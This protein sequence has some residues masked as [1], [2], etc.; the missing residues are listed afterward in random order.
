MKLDEKTKKTLIGIVAVIA[1]IVA[2]FGAGLLY[3]AHTKKWRKR[4]IRGILRANS[5]GQPV[6]K[7]PELAKEC[8]L[9][10]SDGIIELEGGIN[11]EDAYGQLKCVLKYGVP[12]QV[13]K[14]LTPTVQEG[15]GE[16]EAT[17]G[18]QSYSWEFVQKR[19]FS[20]TFAPDST[21]MTWTLSIEPEN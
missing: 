6:L 19:I 18:G 8:G 12:N 20:G 9:D 14:E 11:D 5:L 10:A 17:F 1:L 3:S 16:G 21:Y 2:G 13:A 7:I 4:P 15:E